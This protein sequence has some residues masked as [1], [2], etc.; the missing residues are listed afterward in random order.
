[1]GAAL[2]RWLAPYIMKGLAIAGVLAALWFYIGHV[3]RSARED[4]KRLDAAA[5]TA[6]GRRADLAA[7]QDARRIEA[8]YAQGTKDAND[9]LLPAMAAANDSLT[10]YLAELRRSLRAPGGARPGDLPGPADRSDIAD[11]PDR[12]SILDADLKK[13]TAIAVR[14]GNAQDWWIREAGKAADSTVR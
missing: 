14:L 2:L 10:G 12:L 13:C 6:A 1:M 7:S 11:G 8:A 5:I 4:Q 9:A 3:E